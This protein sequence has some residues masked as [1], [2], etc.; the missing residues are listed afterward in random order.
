M[1]PGEK[2]RTIPSFQLREAIRN[3]Q[4]TENDSS[5]TEWY[6]PLT[7]LT[8]MIRMDCEVIE[9]VVFH[10]VD[11]V[12]NSIS[13]WILTTVID[14]ILIKML[15]LASI[16]IPLRYSNLSPDILN[17]SKVMIQDTPYFWIWL[18]MTWIQFYVK[19]LWPKLR[20]LTW[21]TMFT[22]PRMSGW[23]DLY[24]LLVD[25]FISCLGLQKTRTSNQ[26]NGTLHDYMTTKLVNQIS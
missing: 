19:L 12:H 9:S 22:D 20:C 26:W 8:M 11:C 15:C 4:L 5:F 10:P 6:S 18:Q 3:L 16:S 2:S 1:S 17:H 14:L 13:S 24:Y 23:E 25:Y 7:L 21:L